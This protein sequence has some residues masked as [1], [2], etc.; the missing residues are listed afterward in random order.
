MSEITDKNF[1]EIF[2]S[3]LKSNPSLWRM[4]RPA[5]KRLA[6]DLNEDQSMAWFCYL[7]DKGMLARYR[8][9]KDIIAIGR[10]VMVPC[11]CPDVFD[12]DYMPMSR[13]PS[14][15]KR[16]ENTPEAR[17]RVITGYA[18][19]LADLRSGKRINPD[20]ATR[21]IYH[22]SRPWRDPAIDRDADDLSA[23]RT[24]ADALRREKSRERASLAAMD[25]SIVP[26]RLSSEAAR[27][28][29]VHEDSL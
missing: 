13:L 5:E 25:P 27:R 3:F 8:T 17:T 7:Q 12:L 19:L 26:S 15:I 1:N 11:E 29:P 16:T 18:S 2:K 20:D 23:A 24:K 9:W 6:D 4:I 28:G 21:E 14:V 10:S 22:P